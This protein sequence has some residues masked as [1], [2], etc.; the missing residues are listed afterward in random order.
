MCEVV[1]VEMQVAVCL[2]LRSTDYFGTSSELHGARVLAA[3]SDTCIYCRGEEET[4][5]RNRT[6]QIEAHAGPDIPV[7][8]ISDEEV[9]TEAIILS[10]IKVRY[11]YIWFIFIWDYTG[12]YRNNGKLIKIKDQIVHL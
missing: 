11:T 7:P 8:G 12:S 9:D 5:F 3:N 4:L 1:S 6:V 2:G 10:L